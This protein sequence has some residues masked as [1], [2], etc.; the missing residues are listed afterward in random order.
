[1]SQSPQAFVHAFL[2]ELSEH[3][4]VSGVISQTAYHRIKARLAGDDFVEFAQELLARAPSAVAWRAWGDFSLVS[5]REMDGSEFPFILGLPPHRQRP[6]NCF[7]GH[8]FLPEI[9]GPLRFNLAH[10]LN[11]Y[12]I[13]LRWSAQDLSAS[14]VF[15]DIV[16]GIRNSAMCFFDS[17]GTAG[18]P[19]VFIEIGMAYALG[20]PMIF[21]EHV[22]TQTAAEIPSD[23]HGL[24][25]I[26]YASYEELFRKLY[27]GLPN[28]IAKNRIRGAA[29][30]TGAPRAPRTPS[31]RSR[32][33]R[34]RG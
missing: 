18:K 3:R 19:N 7:V 33:S 15:A 4:F 2:S 24:F 28:F 27:F 21:T 31:R 26:Q 6:L 30:R 29:P 22:G 5:L 8:R 16:K 14:G 25:R 34:S 17:Y 23:L 13:R 11:P 9:E 1:L 32:S 12:G 20:V 10:V